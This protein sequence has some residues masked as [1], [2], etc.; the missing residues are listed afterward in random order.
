MDLRQIIDFLKANPL[1]T[2]LGAG[3]FLFTSLL[4]VALIHHRVTTGIVMPAPVVQAAEEDINVVSLAP[5]D[6]AA[7]ATLLYSPYDVPMVVAPGDTLMGILTEAGADRREAHAAIQAL[8]KVYSPRKLKPGQEL[9][10]SFRP[11]LNGE[12]DTIDRIRLMVN[13]TQDVEVRRERGGDFLADSIHRPLERR[14]M[15]AAGVINSSLYKSAKQ[16]GLPNRVMGDL[17]HIF[18]F[19]VDFQRQVQPG[20]S[21][22]LMYEGLFDENGTALR[23][24]EILMASMTLS[25]VEHKYYRFKGS[26]GFYDYYDE[27]G[28][29]ARKTL[30]M[31]PIDGARISSRYGMRRHPILGYNKMHRG[32]DFAAR[33]GTPV[34]AAGNGIVEAA[35]RNGSYGKYIRIRHNK[36]Y[37]TAYAHLSGYGPGIRK[38]RRVK[39]GQVI[40]FVGSTGRS[41]GPHLHYEVHK[42]GRKVN[43]SSVRLPAGRNLKGKE[44]AAFEEHRLGLQNQ[45]AALEG[46]TQLAEAGGPEEGSTEEVQP[47]DQ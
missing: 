33:T 3:V 14:L 44:L 37:K 36:T 25:G 38:G 5:P 6:S 8:S 42:N 24:G 40:G 45:Y 23:H 46:D 43:P 39:Q 16:I 20:D 29:S 2:G 35:G 7:E 4:G 12:G 11:S 22:T 1:V 32:L 10:V 19:D 17:I 31:T 41:T 15:L 28:K 18:S 47:A 30:L 21:Y 9:T 13:V 34:Y 27:N 26:N